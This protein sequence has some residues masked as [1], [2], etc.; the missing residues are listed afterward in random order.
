MHADYF[1]GLDLGQTTDYTAL[2]V[3]ERPSAPAAAP[4]SAVYLVRHLQRFPVGTPYTDIVPAVARLAATKPLAE[5]TIRLAVDH[6]GVGRPVV[7]LLRRTPMPVSLEPITITGGHSVVDANDGSKHVPKKDLVGCLL[8]LLQSRRLKIARMLPQA[9][10]LVRELNNFR[11][12]V[13][14]AANDTFEG[15]GQH[16]DLVLAVA[17][18]CWVAERFPRWNLPPDRR[19]PESLVARAPKGVFLTTWEEDEEGGP[20]LIANAP[21]GVFLT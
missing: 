13:T 4:E 3:V 18:A 7:D 6:T 5:Q 1:I 20:G 12:K 8:V 9:D 19:V 2:A 17:L 21:P 16:D 15:E 10:A 11:V 14:A